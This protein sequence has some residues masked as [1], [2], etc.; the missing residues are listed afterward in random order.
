MDTKQATRLTILA[1]NTLQTIFERNRA[2][3]LGLAH[4]TQ[5]RTIDR[6][7][8]SLRDGIKTLE[9][10]LNAAEE[11]GAKYVQRGTVIL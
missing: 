2:R 4:E 6:N 1:D 11:A 8:A 5:D 3:D 10:Q 7:L 9:S